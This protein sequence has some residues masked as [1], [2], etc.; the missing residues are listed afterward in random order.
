MAATLTSLHD[1]SEHDLPELPGAGRSDLLVEHAALSATGPVR[2][3]NEDHLGWGRLADR[4]RGTILGSRAGLDTIDRDERT[5]W[6]LAAAL[7]DERP[8]Q[9]LLFAVADGLGAY[10]GGDVA[11]SLAIDELLDQAGRATGN[12]IRPAGVLRN[13]FGAANQRV[14]DAALSGQGTRKMQ[15]TLTSLLLSP[16]EIHIA[17]VGDCRAY[18]LRGDALELLTTDHTQVMEML[19]LKLISPDQA[20]DHPARYAL[21][22]SLGAELIVRADIG[23]EPLVDGDRYLLCSDGLWSKVDA[24]EISGALRSGVEAACQTLV[25]LAVERGG[26]DNASAL[27]VEVRVAGRPPAQLPGWRRFFRS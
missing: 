15:T 1:L 25:G 3:R 17:H 2:A 10:G 21:T 9:G 13:A 26:E 18:R 14:F 4:G 5:S 7:A 24:S 19:R 12:A 8:G 22:R 16:G 23:R 20:A 27:A 6:A 11:S